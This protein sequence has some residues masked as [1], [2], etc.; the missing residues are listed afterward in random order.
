MNNEHR[1]IQILKI[2]KHSGTKQSPSDETEISPSQVNI[3]D[4]ISF[5][6]ELT[7]KELAERLHLTPPTISVGVKK[8]EK[9]NL[10]IRKSHK[11]DGRIVRLMLSGEGK[12]LHKQIKE[13]RTEKVEKILSRLNPQ[14]QNQMITLLEKA[15]M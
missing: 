11:K 9:I 12:I 7:V 13:Y 6:G 14:E 8:L 3:I 4:E 2:L 1:L 10:L 15:L 5:A